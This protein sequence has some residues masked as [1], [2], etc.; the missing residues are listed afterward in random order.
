MNRLPRFNPD[1][2]AYGEK[3]LNA[4]LSFLE[5]HLGESITK[6]TGRYDVMD[7]VTE[8]KKDLEVKT[9][10]SNYHYNQSFIKKEG[11]LVPACKINHARESG[12]PFVCFY[13]WKADESIWK[14][15]YS[16]KAMEGLKPRVPEWNK[17]RQLHYYI[18]QDRWTCIRKPNRV[19]K[20]DT[21]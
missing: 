11:W 20:I 6:T 3:N 5:S 14:F 21:E 17:D 2:H 8:S 4:I 13:Y 16:E 18:P 7:C 15:E 12:R 9:R 1:T 19:L 10:C